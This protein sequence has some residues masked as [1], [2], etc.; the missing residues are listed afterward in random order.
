MNDQ[1]GKKDMSFEERLQ[2]VQHITVTIE[3]GTLPLEDAVQEYERGM[4]ILADLDNE[5]NDMNR[6]LTV[7]QEGK[8]T[9]IP[10]ADV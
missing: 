3:N 1:N 10:D 7:L 8:E 6:R 4:K 2:A 9:E 5:L